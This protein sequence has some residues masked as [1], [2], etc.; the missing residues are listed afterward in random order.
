[1]NKGEKILRIMVGKKT[2]ILSENARKREEDGLGLYLDSS[3]VPTAFGKAPC[4]VSKASHAAELR[5]SEQA[6]IC[7]PG[8]RWRGGGVEGVLHEWQHQVGLLRAYPSGGQVTSYDSM[9]GLA[10]GSKAS[11]QQAPV[12]LL[13]LSSRSNMRL[14]P[15]PA[16]GAPNLCGHRPPAP[17]RA[18]CLV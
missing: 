11:R 9:W 7:E 2:S 5:G 14:W 16:G 6:C 4:Q 15:V 10:L 17:R 1:M 18:L 12:S 3:Q 13:L 8:S